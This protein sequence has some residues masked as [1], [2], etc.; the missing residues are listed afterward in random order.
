MGS[1]DRE[2]QLLLL[3]LF[4]EYFRRTAWI[5]LS[6][7]AKAFCGIPFVFVATGNDTRVL[8]KGRDRATWAS[9]SKRDSTSTGMALRFL[10][11][12]GGAIPTAVA[13][14]LRG[15]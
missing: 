6:L 13:I 3:P 5:A 4:A 7:R 15:R 10:P 12:G 11:G 8:F 2:L 1:L 14:F 9:A